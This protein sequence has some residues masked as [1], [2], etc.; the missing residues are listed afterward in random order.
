MILIDIHLCVLLPIVLGFHVCVLFVEFNEN[1]P[2][3]TSEQSKTFK[4]WSCQK[5]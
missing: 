1:A 3:F 2:I 4:L 5:V